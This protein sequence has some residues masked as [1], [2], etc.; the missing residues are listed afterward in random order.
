MTDRTTADAD[1]EPRITPLANGVRVVTLELPHLESACVSVFVRTGSVHETPALSGISHVVEHM[2][3]KGT[4]TRNCQQI[5]LDAERL[6]AEVNA[7]TDKDHT[8]YHMRGL[9]R[10]AGRFVQML[11]DIVR[12]G[13]F[14]Q[15]ELERERQVI[16]QELA[17]DEDDAYSMAYRLF[18]KLCY[19]R[20]PLAQPVIGLRRNIER[21]TRDDLVAFVRRQQSGAN[22]VVAAAGRIDA[23]AVVRAAEAAFG[24]MP[25]G[26]ENRVP[27][28]VW[29]GGFAAR[30]MAGVSQSHVVLGFPVPPSTD[31]G[32][33]V[34]VVASALFG[35]GMSSPLMDEIRE[36]RGLVYY[37]AC[38]T[39]ISDLAGQFV[40]EASMAPENVE[41]FASEL[42][43]L[44]R[45]QADAIDP[46][47]LERAR[48]QIAVR[49]LHVQER[50]YR[51]LEEAALDVFA[52]GRVR[53]RAERLERLMAVGTE[54]LRAEF[55]RMLQAPASIAI[56]GKVRPSA[57]AH[58][59]ALPG[60]RL[61]GSG[62]E[63]RAG[64][65]A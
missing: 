24:G 35:E 65:A 38:S 12:N 15:D 8:A 50:P 47:S 58:L 32:H 31:P 64:A 29:H 44:L 22:V 16:L 14:P 63:L 10:D 3:F 43:R 2:A 23:D 48:N 21:F 55:A 6:G 42:V 40:V 46:V 19:G 34:A 49:R 25:R 7:H 26:N 5:N 27:S 57:Q 11:G 59:K 54:P 53:G 18:D 45:A 52:F 56:A 1:A 51:R 17:E 33:G 62:S 41:T 4:A 39:D 20:H 9:A 61:A 36:R 37:A 28:P 13:S 60:L 30:R